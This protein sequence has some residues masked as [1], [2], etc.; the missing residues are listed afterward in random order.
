MISSS[1][2][3]DDYLNPDKEILLR[4][5]STKSLKRLNKKMSIS[6]TDINRSEQYFLQSHPFSDL[7]LIV[8]NKRLYVDKSILSSVSK[9]FQSYFQNEN[10]N[11][12]EILDIS[13][14]DMIELLQFLYPQFQCTIN[15]EN[16]TV[17]LILGRS[18]TQRFDIYFI[19]QSCRSFILFYLSK[20][21]Y[22]HMNLIEQENGS[23]LKISTIL[24]NLLIWFREF[25]Y[26]NDEFI[27]EAILEKLCQCNNSNFY[28]SKVFYELKENVQYHIFQARAKYLEKACSSILPI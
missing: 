1:I 21:N 7:T 6:N 27:C 11:S 16:V 15:Y 13:S 12:I 25:F 9:V 28:L 2:T 26:I 19:S 22:I 14:N 4:K 3:H 18:L 20:F 5:T 23:R 17:L 8:Q 10:T 24:D